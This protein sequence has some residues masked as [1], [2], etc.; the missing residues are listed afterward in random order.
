MLLPSYRV[1]KTV[2]ALYISFSFNP[3]SDK[4]N[5]FP[6]PWASKNVPKRYYR[7][8]GKFGKT[9][10]GK[11]RLDHSICFQPYISPESYETLEFSF[12]IFMICA[13]T[14]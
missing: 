3:R 11:K 9:E 10:S 6:P 7:I 4:K 2:F 13:Q 14:S 8:E 5:I 1:S 12:L